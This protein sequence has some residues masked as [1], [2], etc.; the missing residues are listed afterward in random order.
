MFTLNREYKGLDDLFETNT[1]GHM[2]SNEEIKTRLNELSDISRD[3]PFSFG[4]FRFPLDEEERNDVQNR[5]HQSVDYMRDAAIC[6]ALCRFDGTIVLSSM[7]VERTMQAF[8]ILQGKQ[9]STLEEWC[10]MPTIEYEIEKPK[11]SVKSSGTTKEYYGHKNGRLVQYSNLSGVWKYSEVPSL[12]E[13]INKV[14]KDETPVEML[15]E[16]GE[17]QLKPSQWIFV[18]R[19]NTM[20]HGAMENFTTYSQ[21]WQLNLNGEVD[22]DTFLTHKKDAFDQYKKASLFI[23]ETFA[24]FKMKYGTWS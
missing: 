24:R 21:L 18:R 3:R 16:D 9:W 6:Y 19:R 1:Q 12:T 23:M 8:L 5:C 10:S 20:A 17:R 7:A 13:A 14:N 2:M 4:N 11:A 22:L 15:R